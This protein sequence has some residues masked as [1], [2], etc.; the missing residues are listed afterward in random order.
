MWSFQHLSDLLGGGAVV[1]RTFLE[2]AVLDVAARLPQHHRDV[3]GRRSAVPPAST[4]LC[5][6]SEAGRCHGKLTSARGAL[7]ARLGAV[8]PDAYSRTVAR[9]VP[10]LSGRSCQPIKDETP[11]VTSLLAQ[12]HG[13]RQAIAAVGVMVRWLTT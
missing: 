1:W 8:T 2:A 4:A 10:G 9:V 3:S 12:Q 11:F 13:A 6:A 7:S 5:S